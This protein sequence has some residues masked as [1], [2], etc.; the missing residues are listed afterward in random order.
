MLGEQ[1][2]SKGDVVL[3]LVRGFWG[4]ERKRLSWCGVGYMYVAGRETGHMW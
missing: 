4:V 1:K 2:T 3:F